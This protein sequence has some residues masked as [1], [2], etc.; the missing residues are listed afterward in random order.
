MRKQRILRAASAGGADAFGR[1]I[2]NAVVVAGLLASTGAALGQASQR[3]AFVANNGNLEGSVTSF[4]FNAN[5]SP[6][7]VAKFVTPGTNPQ[8]ISIT[9]NGKYLATGAGTA[10]DTTEQLTIMQ[11]HADATLSL[12]GVWLVPDSPLDVHW[13]TDQYLAVTR[14]N[15]SAQN[16]VDTYRFDPTVPSF[17][18]VDMQNTGTFTAYLAGHPNHKWVYA[19]DSG[20]AFAIWALQVNP[21]GTIDLLETHS[22]GTLYPLGSGVSHD[23]K[24]LYSTAGIS[25]DGHKIHGYSIGSDGR[26]TNLAGSPFTSPGQSPKDVAFSMDDT[27][28][29]VGHGTDATVRSF[30][31]NPTTGALTSTGFMFDVGTQG[32]L[33][34]LQ[35]LGDLLLVTDNSMLDGTQGLYSFTIHA[36][37]SFTMNGTIVDTQG[38]S[39][40]RIA[41]WAPVVL[42]DMNCDGALD[43]ADIEPFFLA[44]GDPSAYQA[45]YPDCNILNGDITGDGTLDAADIEAFF[46]LLAG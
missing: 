41:I 34:D 6:H 30:L 24:W 38:V 14:T 36:N 13:M 46:A 35:V 15:L 20:S 40:S 33:G 17:T 45:A 23:G 42:G 8:T 26:L 21:D 11:V 2:W 3:A 5:G 16:R 4:T 28:L 7:F 22:T 9:P 43:A 1:T 12:V 25:G 31:I 44:I 27:I 39:P 18:L 10:S 29:F 32:T 19:S 37:G